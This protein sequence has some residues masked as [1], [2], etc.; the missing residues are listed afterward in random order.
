MN[1]ECE[2]SIWSIRGVHF[3]AQ[4]DAGLRRFAPIV[5]C[6]LSLVT[7]PHLLLKTYNFFCLF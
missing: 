1:Y 5:T 7:N 3:A 4:D 2:A 6:H